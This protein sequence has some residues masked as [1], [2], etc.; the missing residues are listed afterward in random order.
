MPKKICNMAGCR[1]LISMD[2]RYCKEHGS[3][4]TVYNKYSR[5][6]VSAKFYSS[7][8]WKKKREEMMQY[9]N[10]MCQICAGEDIVRVA[11]VVDHIK[12]FKDFPEL[13]LEN[14]NLVPLC[15]FHH[16]AKKRK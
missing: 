10:G 7:A 1:S 12:E 9:Y 15:H 8:A 6:K 11:N 14:D 16:N 3:K 13:S 4:D 2:R 5:D